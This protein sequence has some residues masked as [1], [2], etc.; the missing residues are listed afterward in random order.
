MREKGREDRQVGERVGRPVHV[1]LREEV[2][3]EKCYRHTSKW[4]TSLVRTVCTAGTN[5][6]KHI[7]SSLV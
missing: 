2:G 1:Y 4:T 7:L 5:L 6:H 3:K